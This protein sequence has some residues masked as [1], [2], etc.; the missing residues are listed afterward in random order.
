MKDEQNVSKREKAIIAI[1]FRDYWSTQEQKNKI[2]EKQNNDRLLIEKEKQE[3]Y[4]LDNIFQNNSKPV[5]QQSEQI[6]QRQALVEVKQ[7]FFAKFINKRNFSCEINYKIMFLLQKC[8]K[9]IVF[10]L[11]LGQ[12]RD[13]VL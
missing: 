2:V 8:N 3:K 13:S 1:L 9:N 10:L 6:P 12:I 7:G 5:I 4:N 11:H